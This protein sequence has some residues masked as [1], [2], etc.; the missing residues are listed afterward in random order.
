MEKGMDRMQR[1]APNVST[2]RGHWIRAVA[3]ALAVAGFGVALGTAVPATA[4]A[5]ATGR[6]M[7]VP[8][9]PNAPE[10]YVVKKGD[11]LWDI[12]GVFLK[13][14]W[15]WPEIWYVN[16]QIQNPH[17]IYPGDVLRLV[18]VDGK[19]RV[20]VDQAGAVRLS[21]EVRSEPL[22]QAIRTVPYDVLMKFTR[23]PSLLDRRTVQDA[24]YIVGFRNKHIIG[25]TENETYAKGLGKVAPGTRFTVLHVGKELRDPD[26]G[27]LLGYAAIYAAT[28]EVITTTGS[29]KWGDEEITH[30]SVLD[31]GREILQG[32]KLVPEKPVFG[33]DFV[34]S[35]PAN[36]KLNGQVIAIAGG[37]LTVG[38]KYS[39]LAINRGK[40]DGLVPGNVVAIFA[41]GQEVRD[42][43]SRGQNWMSYT[44]TYDT[45]QLPK[46]RSGT[47]MLFQVH[48]RMSYGIVVESTQAMRVGDFIKHP[49][50]GHSDTGL[51]DFF[52]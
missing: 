42:L 44:A 51:A 38:G 28:V 24:P 49:D 48:D 8:L 45:V 13:Y 30:L 12:A 43:F 14:P 40:R 34:V 39:T 22:A 20:T 15:Y 32:D 10:T 18:Y 47:L 3:L 11:T 5:Q 25:S 46:E 1:V 21:P 50:F 27:D 41:R 29:D 52:R 36:Q 2:V 31:S 9:A 6:S 35:A 16:P 17:W 26:D 37:D 4:L 33:D 23:R 19:P 7:S